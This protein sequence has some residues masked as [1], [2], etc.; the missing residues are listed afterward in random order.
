MSI[1]DNY[2]KFHRVTQDVTHRR[3][4]DDPT[5]SLE[6]IYVQLVLDVN[7]EEL[8]VDLPLDAMEILCINGIDPN[9]ISRI[10]LLMDGMCDTYSFYL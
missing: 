1:E 9:N 7:N 10:R 5:L 2:S 4:F 3:D 6:C 8:T